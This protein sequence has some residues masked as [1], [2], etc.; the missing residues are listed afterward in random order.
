MFTTAINGATMGI[1]NKAEY[2]AYKDS[3]KAHLIPLMLRQARKHLRLTQTQLGQLVG[4]SYASISS[5]EGVPGKKNART[6][7]EITWKYVLLML[8]QE[9]ITFNEDGILVAK[10]KSKAA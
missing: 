9:G 5:W 4:A 8:E 7:K 3:R 10:K 6:P 1:M 2:E